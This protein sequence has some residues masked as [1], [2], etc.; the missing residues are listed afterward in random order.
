MT[1][2]YVADVWGRLTDQEVDSLCLRNLLDS[3]SGVYFFKDSQ[4]RFIRVSRDCAALTDRMPAQMRGL[5]DADLTDAEHARELRE[6]ERRIIETG[7]PLLDKEEADRLANQPDTWVE[8]SKYPLRD[9]TGAIVGTFGFS[10]DVTRWEQAEAEL[11]LANARLQELES[12][13]RVIL[14]TSSD[15]IAM[16]DGELRYQFVNPTG[17]RWRGCSFADLDGRTDREVGGLPPRTLDLWESVLRRVL[18]DGGPQD[19]E[20]PGVIGLGGEGAWFHIAL[21]PERDSDGRVVAVLASG[22]DITALKRAETALAHQARHDDLTGLANRALMNDRLSR[23][24]V[25]LDRRAGAVA[26]YYIDLDDFKLIND[27]HGHKTGDDVI[28]E[29]AHR[30]QRA[31]RRQDTV[32]RMG[33]DE[34]VIV[35][36]MQDVVDVDPLAGRIVNELSQRYEVGGAFVGLTGSVGCAVTTSAATDPELLVSAADHAMYAA[37]TAGRNQYRMATSGALPGA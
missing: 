35:A 21:T 33:G 34:F 31:A 24:I 30:L 37:K 8:T 2:A 14:D 16:Y 11:T 5:T 25:R 20:V 29:A 22:R 36:E 10:R 13:L 23:A 15:G 18:D 27:R 32:A 3:N 1:D 26:V 6:D 7:K 4:G 19:L 12:R 17:E 28:L 9:D